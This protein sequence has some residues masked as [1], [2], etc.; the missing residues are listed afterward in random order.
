MDDKLK[1][2]GHSYKNMSTAII[3]A[4][5]GHG[6]ATLSLS[7][8][9]LRAIVTEA[10]ADIGPGERVL[11]IVPDK[12]RDDN[13]DQLVPFAAEILAQ[14][15]IGRFDA[16]IAQGTHGPMNEA[17]KRQ[18]IGWSKIAPDNIG[19]I[20][21]HRWD[22][23]DELVTLGELSAA[24]IA[25]LTDGLMREA[26]PVRINALLAPGR[27]DTVLVFGATMPHEVAGFAGGAKYF[28]PGI[29]GPELTHLT[30]WLG[31]LATIENV[32]GRIETPTRRVIEAAAAL[33]SARIISFTSVSTR[34][35]EGL[36]T[37][38]L[39]A[40]D[41]C[42]AFRRAAEVS[43]E[44]HIKHIGRKYKRVVAL[45]DRHYDELWVGGKASYKLGSII[46]T[47][48]EL[49]IYAPQLKQLSATH[50]HLIEK[51]GYAPLEQV[52]EMVAG[53]DE[54]RANL[55]VAA[56]L[57]HVSYGSAR[58]AAGK[59]APRYRITLAS[60][61]TEAACLRVNL[62]FLDHRRFNLEDYRA[63]PETLV[64][65]DAGRDLYL[66]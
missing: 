17:E 59:L 3:N 42:E 33:V 10:L 57:A 40:G 24:H 1:F 58:N 64:V 46:E 25:E 66:V 37:H 41:L 22:R 60:A 48:G 62:G 34:N 31:A 15:N 51:Y 63:D 4:V 26:V 56:H 8:E 19:S 45:L 12:T 32:I 36:Q 28:F 61:V 7:S 11:A 23:D 13:T 16:V 29:A 55:C 14:K 44:V 52:R 49:I 50:G 20:F 6:G 5:V 21:D 54:L 38:A 30:H 47:G 2:V 39:F 18:K 9:E 43:S 53:S 35:S 65:E 27:Y